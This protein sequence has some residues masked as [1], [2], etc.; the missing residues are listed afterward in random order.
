MEENQ[1]IH[2]AVPMLTVLLGTAF[3]AAFNENL[4]NV[5]LVKIMSEFNV[6]AGTAQW[7]VTGYMLVTAIIVPVMAF[8][9]RRFSLRQV[10]FEGC[11][12]LGIGSIAA[13]FAPNFEILL[14]SRLVQSVGTGIFIPLMMTTILATIPLNRVG[15]FISI[16]GCCITLGPALAPVLSGIFV[17]FFGWRSVFLMP[18]VAI[19]ILAI[20]GMIFVKNTN[21]PV[22][23]RLDVLSVIFSAAGLSLFVFGISKISGTPLF[24]I[25]LIFAGTLFLSGF[26]VRQFKIKTPVL[27][28]TPMKNPSFAV[29]CFFQIVAMM[30]TFSMSV[31]LPLFY[32]AAL[33]I[34]SLAAG[35][36]LLAPIF[37]NALTSVLGGKIMDRIGEW[38]LLPGGF[39]LI[40]LGLSGTTIFG[41]NALLVPVLLGSIAVYAGVG[42]V[43]SPS[44]AAGL[45]RLK[46]ELH[47]HGVA[48]LN[49]FIQIAACVGPA[50]FIGILSNVFDKESAAGTPITS[51]HAHGF[52]AAVALAALIAFSGTIAAFFY[53]KKK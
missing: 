37:V 38:P 43:F 2:A 17:T 47:P 21:T 33:G 8:F 50:L 30:T 49:T 1:K 46:T 39:L 36:L 52:A 20:S 51:A 14:I 3:C 32:Q 12:F 48:I 44:Q 31:L 16:G 10:F 5:A 26:A 24:A 25:S 40:A 18:S 41:F 53:A 22:K 45:R 19:A 15:V 35:F 28:L 29:A 34:S 6:G 7:L 11:A 27:D 9:S 23:L 42:F 4:I 13:I